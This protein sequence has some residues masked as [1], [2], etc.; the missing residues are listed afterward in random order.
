MIK[1]LVGRDIGCALL[2]FSDKPLH[3]FPQTRELFSRSSRPGKVGTPIIMSLSNDQ[4]TN[5]D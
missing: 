1:D 4:D 3:L 2:T 5:G